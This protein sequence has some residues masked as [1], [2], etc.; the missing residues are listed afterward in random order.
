[1]RGGLS[2]IDR[3]GWLSR[4][5]RNHPYLE[6]LSKFSATPALGRAAETDGKL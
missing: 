6:A 3:L 5:P 4:V 1:M 2:P